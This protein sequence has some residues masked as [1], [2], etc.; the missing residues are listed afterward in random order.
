M[1]CQST[2]GR[3]PSDLSCGE[4]ADAS[5]CGFD[6]VRLVDGLVEEDQQLKDRK[7]ELAEGPMMKVPAVDVG[8]D[9]GRTNP[10]II[11]LSVESG[12]LAQWY[13]VLLEPDDFCS[14]VHAARD[15]KLVNEHLFKSTFILQRKL[16]SLPI[17]HLR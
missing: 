12:K 5:K 2:T 9:D 13:D 17:S 10:V 4:V 14:A 7:Q 6:G 1:V 8:R 3:K 15:V 11:E 16:S